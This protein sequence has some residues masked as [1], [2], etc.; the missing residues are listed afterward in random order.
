MVAMIETLDRWAAG[1]LK[2]MGAA[3]WQA[4]LLICVAT[5]IVW[6]LKRSS[7]VV[8]Y[9]VWQIVAI[10]LLLMPFWTFAVPIPAWWE[11]KTPAL[12]DSPPAAERTVVDAGPMPLQRPGVGE[13]SPMAK[14]PPA[15]VSFWKPWS[16]V[17]WQAWLLLAWS[18][19]VIWQ[20]VRLLVQR[21]RLSRLLGQGIPPDAELAALVADLSG[22]IGL[23]RP[24]G[25]VSIEGDCPL[26]VCG[27]RRPMLVLPS[28]LLASLDAAERRQVILHELGHVKRHDLIWGWPVEIARIAYFFNPLVYWAA[29]QLRLERE[30]ACDQLA[31]ARS[32][33]SAA[34]YARTLV[35]VVSHAS[36]QA[37]PQIAAIAAGLAGSQPAPKQASKTNDSKKEQRHD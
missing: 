23:R 8:R 12:P 32:G 6:L 22:Q 1:W 15:A 18:V 26:F 5:I 14:M 20:I 9:W 36:E 28:R 30:L 24:P 25:A 2:V 17:T 10:K 27:L 13:R 37:T 31:M 3:F 33:H 11:S 19:V 21:L 7:P 16:S 4:V 35:Q 34:D 29:Y